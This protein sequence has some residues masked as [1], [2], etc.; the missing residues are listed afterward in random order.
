[1]AILTENR[2][3]LGTALAASAVGKPRRVRRRP[4]VRARVLWV[5]DDPNIT[6]A[7]SRRLYRKG[8]ELWP[9][10]DGMQGYWFAVTR[11]PDIIVTDLRMPRWD[12][13]DLLECLLANGMTTGVPVV[14]VSGYVTPAERSRL[15]HQGVAAVLDK[16]VAWPLLCKTFERL[17]VE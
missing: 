11:K 14:V 5:D 13:R 7:L 4:T 8:I 2:S 16:P 10:S 9:A 17:L 6:A 3:A 12:G 15:E 1:M